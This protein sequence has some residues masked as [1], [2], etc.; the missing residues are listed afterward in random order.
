MPERAKAHKGI[1]IWLA[2]VLVGA[3]IGAGGAILFWQTSIISRLQAQLAASAAE[4]AEFKRRVDQLTPA[5]AG[6]PP[7]APEPSAPPSV[8]REAGP[9]AAAALPGSEQRAEHLRE[10]LAQATADLDRLQARVS[11]LQGQL[12]SAAADN[13]RL[14]A[15]AEESKKGLTDAEQTVETLRAQLAANNA[16]VAQLESLNARMKE[17]AASGKQSYSQLQQIV[18]DLD[19]IFRRREM[20]LN[21]ILRRYREITEQYRAMSGVSASRDR[22]AAAVGTAEISRIQNSIALAEEDLKQISALNAQASRLE[23][24]LQAK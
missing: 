15:A 3:V 6:N 24:K 18:S 12:E 14:S 21:N 10:S 23:A 17:D 4:N 11:D 1:P 2:V 19:G 9:A 7:T 22:E 8:R 16:R 5:Q 13:R 20:Y